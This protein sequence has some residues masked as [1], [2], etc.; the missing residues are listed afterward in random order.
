VTQ[1]YKKYIYKIKS[2]N[3]ETKE[4]TYHICVHPRMAGLIAI[5]WMEG[6]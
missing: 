1:K 3:V 2:K 6:R 4:K 5:G